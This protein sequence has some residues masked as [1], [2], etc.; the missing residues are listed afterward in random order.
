MSHFAHTPVDADLELA[1][2]FKG[3]P[4]GHHSPRLQ[5]LLNVFRGEPIEGKYVLISTKPHGEWVLGKLNGRAKPI[6]IYYDRKFSSEP[7]GE[8]EVF[9]LRWRRHVGE[10]LELD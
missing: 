3:N 9:K 1:R 6:D 8:W 4:H 2:E 7:E 5:K 10:D